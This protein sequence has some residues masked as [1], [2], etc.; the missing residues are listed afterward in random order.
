M[1]EIKHTLAMGLLIAAFW[2]MMYPQFSLLQETY[3]AAQES[4]SPKED[5]F[6]ILEAD[7]SQIVV[8]SRLWELWE[9]RAEEKTVHTAVTEWS[10]HDY[11]GR[12]CGE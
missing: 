10:F 8:K 2:G 4:G 7:R 12:K 5:F 6:A 1:N 3:V 11:F 9:E